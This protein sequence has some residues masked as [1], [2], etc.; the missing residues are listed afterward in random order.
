MRRNYQELLLK[1]DRKL[2]H[3]ADLA[4]LFGVNSKNTLYK[5]LS[6]LVAKKSLYSIYKGMY[7]TSPIADYNPQVLGAFA[8]NTYCY[9]STEST[10]FNNGI[11]NQPPSKLTFLSKFNKN[12]QI[13]GISIVSR[14]LR[15]K[16][17]YNTAGVTLDQ[18]GVFIA[19]IERAI[20]DML[21]FSPNYYFDN[22]KSVDWGKVKEIKKE[23][24]F[25]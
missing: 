17:L 1:Q 15:N 16:F 13:D 23:V 21:Y 8:L 6:R 18:D 9:L 7:S 4:V 12:I 11:I 10:L 2:F 3:T 22:S 14:K 24:G 20:C 5:A 19:S 25:V